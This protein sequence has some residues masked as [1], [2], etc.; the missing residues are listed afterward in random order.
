MGLYSW[1]IGKLQW[2]SRILSGCL[3]HELAQVVVHLSALKA[4]VVRELHDVERR[5]FRADPRVAF[6]RDPCSDRRR[7]GRQC[8]LPIRRK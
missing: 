1:S 6:G 8:D 7:R 2:I 5:V 3:R 4:L